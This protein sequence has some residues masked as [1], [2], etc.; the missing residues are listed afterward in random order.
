MGVF[1]YFASHAILSSLFEDWPERMR[2]AVVIGKDAEGGMSGEAHMMLFHES[3]APGILYRIAE[4]FDCATDDILVAPEL[5]ELQEVLPYSSWTPGSGD[6]KWIL[7]QIRARKS[8]EEEA[9]DMALNIDFARSE[10]IDPTALMSQPQ[11]RDEGGEKPSWKKALAELGSLIPD[12][13]PKVPRPLLQERVEPPITATPLPPLHH[14][15]PVMPQAAPALPA[16]D[17]EEPEVLGY[18]SPDPEALRACAMCL[19]SVRRDGDDILLESRGNPGS[20]K[21]EVRAPLDTLIGEDLCSFLMPPGLGRSWSPTEALS[22]RIPAGML[23]AGFAESFAA[24]SSARIAS[25]P[26][27]VQIRVFDGAHMPAAQDAVNET[28]ARRRLLRSAAIGAALGLA[29]VGAAA[30]IAWVRPGETRAFLEGISGTI[31]ISPDWVERVM[32]QV[33]G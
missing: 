21:L 28:P 27:A 31:G 24:G 7:G 15:K 26:W 11:D 30:G 18:F 3:D 9:M 19:A 10:G 17:H 13:P 14:F 5:I 2:L 12:A 20:A 32:M 29:I 33:A 6:E 8:L 23:P 25:T 22:L 1:A 16:D 4:K